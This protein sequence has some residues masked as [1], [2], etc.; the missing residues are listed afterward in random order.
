MEMIQTRSD[1]ATRLSDPNA[2]RT[3]TAEERRKAEY[4]RKHLANAYLAER[5][6]AEKRGDKGHVEAIDAQLAW[7]EQAQPEELL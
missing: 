3:P 5:E 7:V 2:P 1:W 4:E 6:T